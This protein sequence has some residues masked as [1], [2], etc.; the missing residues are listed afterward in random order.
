MVECRADVRGDLLDALCLGFTALGIDRRIGCC[1]TIWGVYVLEPKLLGRRGGR[2]GGALV[3]GALP[4]IFRMQRIRDALWLGLGCAVLANS[5]PFEG[6]FIALPIAY[7]VLPWKIRWKA[8]ASS[9]FIKKILLPLGLMLAITIVG[10]GAYNKQITG[11]AGLFPYLLY[12]HTYRDVPLFIWQPYASRAKF[13]HKIMELH[14]KLYTEK[15]Y[16]DKRTWKGFVRDMW[17]DSFVMSRFFFGYP[18]ALPSWA[19]LLLFFFHRKTAAR[20]WL[21]LLILLGTCASMTWTS[22]SHYFAPLTGLAVLLITMG[23]RSWFTGLKLYNARIGLAMVLFLM[24][25]QL[26]LNIGLTPKL[27]AVRS[28]ARSI[29]STNL[30]LPASFT[31]A[32]LK[33]ILKKRGGK[34]LVIV[35]YPLAHNYFLEWVY[36]EADIDHAPD[37]VGPGHG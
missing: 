10:I 34:Y 20:F 12:D 19:V 35:K 15:Y 6:F 30:N 31:R 5:R 18:L 32:T 11:N 4:R 14:E 37:C 36:N 17:L 3:F 13:D 28:L 1:F 27:P 21:A 29:Q 23:L 33:N 8:L 16:N 2:D 22:K 7:L 24:G 9:K 26:A 25:F